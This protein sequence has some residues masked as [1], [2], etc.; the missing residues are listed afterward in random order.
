[1]L[2]QDC[3][4]LL[5]QIDGR[6]ATL[7]SGRPVRGTEDDRSAEWE[8]AV[9]TADALRR[10]VADTARS[11]AADRARV[12]AAVRY[13]VSGGKARTPSWRYSSLA[14]GLVGRRN[15]RRPDRSLGDD[16]RVVNEILRDL[17]GGG[18][19]EPP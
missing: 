16:V 15:E 8:V 17:G 2:R 13:F 9:R 1:M 4:V 19:Q 18:D 6:L 12:R 3:E 11:S 14:P 5:R 7:R 10:L